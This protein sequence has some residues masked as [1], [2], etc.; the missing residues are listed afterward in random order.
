MDDRN[1]RRINGKTAFF[2]MAAGYAL[3]T[4]SVLI[5]PLSSVR[6]ETAAGIFGYLVGILFWLGIF[7][8]TAL[9]LRLCRQFTSNRKSRGRNRKVDRFPPV[10]HFFRNRYARAADILL[11][12]GIA[13][14]V[15][16]AVAGQK[17]LWLQWFFMVVT[18]TAVWLHCLLN[19]AVFEY[20]FIRKGVDRDKLEGE[21]RYEKA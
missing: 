10:F 14:S 16:S 11:F 5:L 2:L 4:V 20:L 3:V 8:G 1:T 9:Y 18:V 21:K 15:A 6:N 7:W 12:V 13:G 17:I 19:G